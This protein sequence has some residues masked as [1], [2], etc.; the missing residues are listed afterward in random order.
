MKKYLTPRQGHF[1][2]TVLIVV[3]ATA[4]ALG[5]CGNNDTEK[6]DEAA[7]TG[8]LSYTGKIGGGPTGGTF[9]T[10]AN[11]MSIYVPKNVEGVQLSTIGSGGSVENVKRVSSG[12]SFLLLLRTRPM[13]SAV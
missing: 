3:L 9:N 4:L 13:P 1:S 11:A 5:G 6:T 7:A 10:F 8:G 12:E 2:I